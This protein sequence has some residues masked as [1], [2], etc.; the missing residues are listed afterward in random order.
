[1]N[2]IDLDN[3]VIINEVS[4]IGVVRVNP[5]NL[6]CSQ[7]Y[8]FWFL[9]LK[10]IVH[11]FLDFKIELLVSPQNQVSVALGLKTAQD[12]RANQTGMTSDVDFRIP[13]HYEAKSMEYALCTLNQCCTEFFGLLHHSVKHSADFVISSHKL[14]M[15][16]L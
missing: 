3:Q 2:D 11:L 13:F 8:V 7:K 16:F 9:T 12:R 14:Q 6:C 4:G 15:L 10:K 5:S 1:M